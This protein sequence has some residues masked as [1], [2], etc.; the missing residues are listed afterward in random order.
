MYFYKERKEEQKI[1]IKVNI[2][3]QNKTEKKENKNEARKIN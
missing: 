1:K 3:P 2:F